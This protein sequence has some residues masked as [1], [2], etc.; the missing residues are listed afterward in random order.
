MRTVPWPRLAFFLLF[1]TLPAFGVTRHYYIAAE[2]VTWDYAPSGLNLTEGRPIP[3]PWAKQTKW[4]KTRYIEY[5]DATFKVRKPQP[6]WLGIMGPVIRGEVGDEIVVDFLNRGRSSHGIHPHG[7]RY[8]KD[9]EGA[10]YV[11]A[12]RG[13]LV[14]PNGRFTYHWFADAGSGPGPGQLSSVVWWYH[15]HSAGL[16]EIN[17]GL[18]GPIIITAKGK[19]RPDGSPK[20]VDREFATSFM[21]FDELRGQDAGLFHAINGY[22]FGNQPLGKAPGEGMTVKAG[23]RVRWYL[24]GMGTEVDLHTP[25]WHGNTVTTNGMRGDMIQLEPGMMMVSDM[26]PDDPGTWLFHCHVNDHILAGMQ[27]RYR[28]VS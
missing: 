24:M 25:H 21:I 7:L 16:S 11:P 10:Y 8:D 1:L 6:E 18:M 17:A 2:D 20:D 27:A 22:V 19:A 13:S 12:G 9:N 26:V 15:P 4:P 3:Q 23:Q 28:V 5:T 14:P